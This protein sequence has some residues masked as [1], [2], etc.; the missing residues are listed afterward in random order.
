MAFAPRLP[1]PPAKS[2]PR[3]DQWVAQLWRHITFGDQF[4]DAAAVTTAASAGIDTT[5]TIVA[6]GLGLSKI[7]ANRLKAGTTIRIR[8]YGTCTAT[9]ARVP[10]FRVRFGTTGTTSDTAIGTAALA[11]SAASGTAIPFAVEI[12]FTVRTVGSTGTIAG[13]LTLHNAGTTGLSTTTVQTI[14]L[15]VAAINTTVD[16]Y[17]SATFA[18]AASAACTCTF[19]NGIIEV[20]KQ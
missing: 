1:Q 16:S 17:L 8:L 18:S 3:F 4:E 20:V 2:D 9:A 15:T 14:A 12:V 5:E 11:A 6:G 19:Q 13:T 7:P 10:T